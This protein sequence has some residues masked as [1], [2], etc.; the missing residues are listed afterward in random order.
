MS[1]QDIWT[2]ATVGGAQGAKSEL[3]FRWAQPPTVADR[4]LVFRIK[5]ASTSTPGLKDQT[6]TLRY[7]PSQGSVPSSPSSER[8][9][10]KEPSRDV[11][12]GRKKWIP[13]WHSS[14]KTKSLRIWWSM[15]YDDLSYTKIPSVNNN[16]SLLSQS[17][18]ECKN[19]TFFLATTRQETSI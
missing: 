2:A 6:Q 5:W 9:M 10:E 11:M 7:R 1:A 14:R 12:D 19:K 15:S 8:E 13:M 16:N 18:L 3:S 17:K 4:V